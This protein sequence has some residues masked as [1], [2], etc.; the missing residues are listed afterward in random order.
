MGEVFQAIS[1]GK[2]AID[3]LKSLA[4]YADEVKDVSKRGEFMRIIG[5]LNL[6]LAETETKLSGHIRE[7]DELKKQVVILQKKV[8]TLE[9]PDSKLT[10][11]DDGYYDSEGDGPFCTGCYDSSKKKIRLTKLP[12]GKKALGKY[13]CP[14]CK[15]NSGR[16]KPHTTILIGG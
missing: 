7:N 1:A 5:D 2:A 14:I 11:K 12:Y 8:E 6:K 3:G 16:Q 10:F 9:N 15:S 13:E 4:Q